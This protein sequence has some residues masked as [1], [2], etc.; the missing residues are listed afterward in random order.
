MK[1]SCLQCDHEFEGSIELDEL[2]WHSVCPECGGSFDADLPEGRIVM[3]F[4]DDSEDNRDGERFPEDFE[5]AL[6]RTYYAF[7]SAEDFMKAWYKMVENPDGMWYW[8]LDN[9]AVICSGAC[10]PSDGEIFA[11]HFGFDGDAMRLKCRESLDKTELP[12]PQ[13]GSSTLSRGILQI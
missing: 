7:D 13:D 12:L 10:D 9:G 1:L 11:D 6:L 5:R 8:V 4:S 3:A 2:G